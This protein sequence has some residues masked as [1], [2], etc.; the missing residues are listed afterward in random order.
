LLHG[1]RNRVLGGLA[2]PAHVVAGLVAARV[3]PRLA[4]ATFL[5]PALLAA[6]ATLLAAAS[7]FLA[8]ATRLAAAATFLAALPAFLFPFRHS[9]S[10]FEV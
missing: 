7:T 10:P 4:A 2:A 6:A 8:A 9:L 3:I 1:K 5:A